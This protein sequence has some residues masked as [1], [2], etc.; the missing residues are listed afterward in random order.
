M[1]NGVG[2]LVA[3]DS[4]PSFSGRT[5]FNPIHRP[6]GM[7]LVEGASVHRRFLGFGGCCWLGFVV[8]RAVWVVVCCC[9]LA[10]DWL[11]FTI[12]GLELCCSNRSG[13]VVSEVLDVWGFWGG[14]GWRQCWLAGGVLVLFGRGVCGG[15]GVRWLDHRHLFSVSSGGSVEEFY[16]H[17][18]VPE[19][20]IELHP[21]ARITSRIGRI[22]VIVTPEKR[23]AMIP[24]RPGKFRP[25]FRFV[26]QLVCYNLDPRATDNKPSETTGNMLMAFLEEETAC[27]W[28]R[29]IFVKIVE[30]RDAS[31]NTRLPFPVLISAICRAVEGLASKY[32]K[33]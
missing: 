26:N 20:G 17:M 19:A 4:P 33:E 31:T 5:G 15:S 1:L 24:P 16:K 7:F 9:V 22:P 27:D 3:F 23:N 11:G 29:Y 25:S 32:F 12:R 8:V 6:L 28:A 10:G 2:T 21:E 14:C 13:D 30:L 18:I